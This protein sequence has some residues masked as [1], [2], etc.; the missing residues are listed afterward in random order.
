MIAR[1]VLVAVGIVAAIA[2][3]A[4]WTKRK[5][6]RNEASQEAATEVVGVMREDEAAPAAT[7]DSTEDGDDLQ[8][9][10]GIGAVSAERLRAID[11]T[12][13]TQIA[14]WS[15]E[16]LE[17]VSTQIKVSAERIKREDWVGQ[18][19]TLAHD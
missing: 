12:T 7:A 9:I 5:A 10:R 1:L 8:A 11:M 13:F 18:A 6:E 19:R 2:G 16:R 4:A 17:S 14:E 15:P 3:A